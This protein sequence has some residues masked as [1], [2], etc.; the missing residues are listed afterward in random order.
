MFE[1][2]QAAKRIGALAENTDFTKR[3]RKLAKM[4]VQEIHDAALAKQGIE[5][6]EEKKDQKKKS[7]PK[8][9]ER[10]KFHTK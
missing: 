6:P 7:S 2:P 4:H 9:L 1:Y 8:T 5:K 10:I 3:M